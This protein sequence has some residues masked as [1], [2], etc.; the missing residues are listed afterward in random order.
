LEPENGTER[1][2]YNNPLDPAVRNF[3]HHETA[4]SGATCN[5]EGPQ[6]EKTTEKCS[7]KDRAPLFNTTVIPL[8]STGRVFA[9]AAA[10][11][12]FQTDQW[13]TQPASLTN[14]PRQIRAT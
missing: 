8:D 14:E 3:A 2:P 11:T 13:A 1:A 9:S 4:A 10:N 7:R 6:D 12:L 5:A